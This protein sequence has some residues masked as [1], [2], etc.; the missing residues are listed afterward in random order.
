[1]SQEN[2]I[3]ECEAALN[4]RTDE[5]VSLRNEKVELT[6]KLSECELS[7]A[8]AKAHIAELQADLMSTQVDIATHPS[9]RPFVL[10]TLLPRFILVF[11]QS[12]LSVILSF[13]SLFFLHCSLFNAHFII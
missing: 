9:Y 4:S 11:L 8:S 1:M 2:Q 3:A 5:I 13:F 7:L 12:Y 6:G 10:L